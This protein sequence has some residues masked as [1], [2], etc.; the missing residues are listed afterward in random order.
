MDYQYVSYSE[1]GELVKGKLSAPTEEEATEM[2]GYA[3]YRV[4][5]LKPYVPFFD[6][7]KLSMEL[8]PVKPAE[9]VL[10]YRQLAMLIE[11]GIDIGTSLDLLKEQ[12]T[13]RTLKRVLAE[14]ASSIRSGNQ[15]SSVLER[16][17]KV[18]SSMYCRLLS[19]G[20]Q[21]GDLEIVLRQV[22]DYM[23]KETA[24]TK[25]TKSAL[26]MPAITVSIAAVVIGLL[27]T[28]IL[29][30][31][32]SMYASL[33][34]EMPP[35][36]KIMIAVGE[37]A[38]S[39]GGYYLLAVLAIIG[40]VF[41]YIKTSGGRY[42]WDKMLLKLPLVGRV[43]HIS[44]LAR[45]CRS[46][47]LLFRTGMP[48]NEVMS[49]IVQGSGNKVLTKA[50]IGVQEEMVKGEGLSRP[51]SKNKLFLPMMVQMIKVG[52]ETGGLDVTLQAVARSYETEAEDRIRSLI[53]LIQPVMTIAIGGVVGL[54]AVTLMSAMT[55]MYGEGF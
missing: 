44:E 40:A 45:Y 36:A 3:G 4:V 13:S 9:I 49:L 48:L 25:E 22:A 15:L 55:A 41:I 19:V 26:M 47:S 17:P 7:G 31:F 29:P 53:A 46:M 28:F 1:S 20:E 14:V 5:S 37:N 30:S 10:L 2:L 42:K 32:T 34:V 27:V 39:H 24:T 16:H 12:A 50:L 54:I 23:E 8:F 6:M 43:R 33:G 38:K 18:F 21:S 35:I 11:S 52:E 51:M